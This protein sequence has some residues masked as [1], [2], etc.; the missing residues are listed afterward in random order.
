V[1]QNPAW[2]LNNKYR[3]TLLPGLPFSNVRA[4]LIALQPFGPTF[5]QMTCSCYRPK[6]PQ[7]ANSC[8]GLL[9]RKAANTIRQPREHTTHV[10]LFITVK[11]VAKKRKRWKCS[12]KSANN[13]F[14][15]TMRDKTTL[16]CLIRSRVWIFFYGYHGPV[17]CVVTAKSLPWLVGTRLHF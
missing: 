1:V 17:M 12:D 9:Q 6:T 5:V 15:M 11:T 3:F 2:T 7:T 4:Y 13:L 10:Y 8:A 14:D 16:Q